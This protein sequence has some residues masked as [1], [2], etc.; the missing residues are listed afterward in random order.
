MKI[1]FSNL[2]KTHKTHRKIIYRLKKLIEKNQFIG[3]PELKSFEKNFCNYVGAKYCI[4]VANGTDA[5][6]I[7]LE[8][9]KLK[10]GSEVIVPVNTWIATA[11]SVVRSGCKLVFCDIEKDSWCLDPESVKK[12]I[13]KN[14]KAIIAV[15]L[16]GNMANWEELN[17]I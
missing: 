17:K 6:E 7:A 12:N 8:S 5:L 13:N 1:E 9:L 10:K 16:F 2:Y 3:G 11:S 15:D 4:G 14:T